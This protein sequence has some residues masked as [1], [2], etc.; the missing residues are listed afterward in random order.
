MKTPV[1]ILLICLLAFTA[2]THAH[3]ELLTAVPAPGSAITNPISEIR[4]TFS[5]PITADSAILLF[6]ENFQPVADIM[7]TVDEA[8]P[9]T[10]ITTLPPLTYGDYTVQWTAVSTDGH[11]TSGSYTFRL[12][13]VALP[14]TLLWQISLT[15]LFLSAFVVLWRRNR[16][17]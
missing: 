4:L 10:L 11:P 6:T 15:L 2:V 8:D 14:T 7:A 3:A 13:R 12:S 5:E 16:N 9:H 1:P 17:R